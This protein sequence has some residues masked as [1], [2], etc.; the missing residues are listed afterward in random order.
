MVA[1]NPNPSPFDKHPWTESNR[2]ALAGIRRL[3]LLADVHGPLA[4]LLSSRLARLRL[5]ARV[6]A[7]G[8]EVNQDAGPPAGRDFALINL[9][10]HSGPAGFDRVLMIVARLGIE[11]EVLVRTSGRPVRR[12]A[13]LFD[14]QGFR[15]VTTDLVAEAALDL[16]DRLA[17]EVLDEVTAAAG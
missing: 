14:V 8:Y 12:T 7:R 1:L 15:T 13:G 2:E 16:I 3:G 5:E 10:V 11:R 4:E 9:Q 17:D 6:R